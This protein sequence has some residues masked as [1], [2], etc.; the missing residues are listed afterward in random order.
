M[1]CAALPTSMTSSSASIGKLFET[2]S[3]CLLQRTKRKKTFI[4]WLERRAAFADSAMKARL[5]ESLEQSPSQGPLVASQ[6]HALLQWGQ[7]CTVAVAMHMFSPSP[8]HTS[9]HD[10]LCVMCIRYHQDKGFQVILVSQ[11]LNLLALG[12]TIAFSALLLLC[13]R[14]GAFHAECVEQ[15]TCDISEV[16]RHPALP[17]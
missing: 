1:S 14:W 11:I 5:R 9:G 15:D 10:T 6:G 3:L 12:F 17:A 8:A 7:A 2:P 13:V 4:T 16:G